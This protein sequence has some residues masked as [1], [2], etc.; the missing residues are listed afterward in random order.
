MLESELKPKIYDLW[1]NF[2]EAKMTNTFEVMEQM[3]YVREWNGKFVVL[4][5]K[6]VVIK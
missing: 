6:V 1:N 5:P 4:H 3:S 2:W